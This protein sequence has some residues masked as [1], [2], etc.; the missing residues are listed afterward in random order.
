[1]RLGGARW[2]SLRWPGISYRGAAGAMGISHALPLHRSPHA[3][4]HSCGPRTSQRPAHN[5]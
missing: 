2:T 1:M 5:L 3:G 4:E